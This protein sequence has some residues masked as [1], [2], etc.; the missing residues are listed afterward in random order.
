MPILHIATNELDLILPQLARHTHLFNNTR[1]LIRT[2]T[3]LLWRSIYS[4]S[5]IQLVSLL[6]NFNNKMVCRAQHKPYYL[7]VLKDKTS[8]SRLSP[9][10]ISPN[11]FYVSCSLIF[12]MELFIDPHDIF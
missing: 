11:L 3:V 9:S 2:L 8:T 12:T 6:E 10:I 5:K 1:H 7:T 4:H